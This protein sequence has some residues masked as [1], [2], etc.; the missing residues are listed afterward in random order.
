MPES[1]HWRF[2]P[3][4]SGRRRLRHVT[5]AILNTDVVE[6]A[7]VG[8]NQR[9][10]RTSLAFDG[11]FGQDYVGDRAVRS[12]RVFGAFANSPMP[13]APIGERFLRLESV[14]RAK[15]R[16]GNQSDRSPGDWGCV[17]TL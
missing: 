15:G 5:G 8:K 14:A 11:V 12:K 10:D 6:G 9:R 4:E 7:D 1:A 17:T 3:V 2:S 13:P 16:A